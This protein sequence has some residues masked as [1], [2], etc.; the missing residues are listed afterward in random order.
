MEA[1]R[2]L[3]D[4]ALIAVICDCG[5][6]RG[7]AAS[8]TL[9]D[10]QFDNVSVKVSCRKSK[11]VKR[12]VRGLDC[13]APLAAW[14]EAHPRKGDPNAPLFCITENI[15]AWRNQYT[16][17]SYNIG[18]PM[19]PEC[20][21]RTV[22]AIWER[23]KRVHP[24]IPKFHPHTGRHYSATK[25]HK[26]LDLGVEELKIRYGWVSNDMPSVYVN[27]SAEDVD[28]KILRKRGLLPEKDI[29]PLSIKC[30]RCGKL[31]PPT[32]TYCGL[33]YSP[34]TQAEAAKIEKNIENGDN[35]I[36][37]ILSN[38]QLKADLLKALLSQ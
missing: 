30:S 20:I 12:T 14:M 8:I 11:T 6:R 2:S 37:K 5:F 1:G 3:R 22:K 15:P 31:N 18:D 34:L 19:S 17:R 25:A 16:K 9:A 32:A 38:P 23:A 4:K 33:C 35:L 27:E 10:V 29:K 28:E 21:T 36:A 26:E 13:T 7:E 24:E